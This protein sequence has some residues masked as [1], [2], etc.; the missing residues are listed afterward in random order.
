MS[1]QTLLSNHKSFL[2]QSAELI[3]NQEKGDV[4]DCLIL[5]PN[6][7][8]ILF[9]RKALTDVAG[10]P[11]WAP[12]LFT[13]DAWIK[14]HYPGYINDELALIIRLHHCWKDL[15]GKESFESFYTLGQMLIKDFNT[16]DETLVHR[17]E[18][19]TVL[20]N[21][22]SWT[23]D[24]LRDNEPALTELAQAIKG[25][26]LAISL[27]IIWQSL[28]KLYDLFH[29]SLKKDGLMTSG[30][31][32]REMVEKGMAEDLTRK[33]QTVYAVG[34][35][36]LLRAEEKILQ[37]IPGLQCIWNMIDPAVAASIGWTHP[38]Q[39]F[40]DDF[41][42]SSYIINGNGSLEKVITTVAASGKQLQIQGLASLLKNIVDHRYSDTVIVLPSQGLLLPL[43]QSITDPVKNVNVSMGLSVMDTSVYALMHQFLLCLQSWTQEKWIDFRIIRRLFAH[44]PLKD[45]TSLFESPYTN[46]DEIVYWTQDKLKEILSGEWYELLAPCKNQ[47]ECLARCLRFLELLY[48]GVEDEIERSATYH[49]FTKIQRIRTVL[50]PQEREWNPVFF[51]RF[52]RRILQHSRLYLPGEPLSGMQ[53]LGLQELAN[54]HF[55]HV[56]VLDANEG[57]LPSAHHQSVIPYSL[58]LHYKLP[59]LEESTRIQEHLF[60]S[61]LA[62]AEKITLFYNTSDVGIGN[63][64]P[65]RWI[66]RLWMG[67]KPH[68]WNISKTSIFSLR[69]KNVKIP[70][71]FN[72]HE[73]IRTLFKKWLKDFTISPTAINIWLTCRLRFY[74]EHILRYRDRDETFDVLDARLFG[75][76]FHDVMEALYKPYSGKELTQQDI[77]ILKNQLDEVIRSQYRK[78]IH[79]TGSM[80]ES[81]NHRLF[82]ETLKMV[83]GKLLE[84]D[85]GFA[86]FT[87]D[88][89]ES[90]LTREITV[91]D[92]PLRFFGKMDR[93]DRNESIIRIVDYKTG[94]YND[95]IFNSSYPKIWERDGKSHKEAFQTLFYAWIYHRSFPSQPIPQIH[96]YYTS[97][98]TS[99]KHTQVIIEGQEKITTSL[100]S[101]FEN[102]LIQMVRGWLYDDLIID[103]TTVV[104]NCV[105]C[106]YRVMC[107]R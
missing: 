103:Q 82:I 20:G 104:K 106:P 6:Q 86:P 22:P 27:K 16:I 28:G 93:I 76:I 14:Q 51:D 1:Q 29:A 10:K 53:I 50:T 56:I 60:W 24:D 77:E 35:V 25:N 61:L 13:L 49:L 52:L 81:G 78:H 87:I 43:L 32:Y 59:G 63:S 15:G 83:I 40:I 99:R 41:Q 102:D 30:R 67:M 94:S 19:F 4:K 3:Y 9:F 12:Q 21:L 58:S 64:E 74:L 55:K 42:G 73:S 89:I 33:Y 62:S 26:S 97:W 65:S 98:D 18:F 96:L 68:H 34:M 95:K 17:H 105:H 88:S 79:T 69:K 100:L 107:G 72:D 85:E 7:R 31:I 8:S 44:L 38:C 84:S 36:H 45:K 80:M 101:R 37:S 66:Q 46:H 90:Q 71:L 54:L 23:E 5:F 70:I 47:V 48:D 2:L 92:I 57:V 91:E 75:S 39:K 11:V